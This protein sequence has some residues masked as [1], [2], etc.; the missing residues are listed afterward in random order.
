MGFTL[1]ASVSAV[2]RLLSFRDYLGNI[3]VVWLL[4][5]DLNGHIVD[6][7]VVSMPRDFYAAL[8]ATKPCVPSKP[9]R[10]QA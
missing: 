1:A 6:Y 10:F 7:R 9:F 3:R 4:R 8:Q 5:I 2:D